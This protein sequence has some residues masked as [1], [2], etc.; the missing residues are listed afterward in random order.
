M[1]Q[2]RGCVEPRR[3]TRPGP[4]RGSGG[5]HG[6]KLKWSGGRRGH[7]SAGERRGIVTCG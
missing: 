7:R 2:W 1:L 5:G 3:A 4:R 6:Q